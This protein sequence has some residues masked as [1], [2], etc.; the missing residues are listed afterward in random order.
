[1]TGASVVG[2]TGIVKDQHAGMANENTK[3]RENRG[4]THRRAKNVSRG[5]AAGFVCAVDRICGIRVGMDVVVLCSGGM[6]SVTAL[7]WAQARWRVAAALSFDYGAKHNAREIPFAAEHAA[8]LGIP[9]QTIALPF[10]NDLFASDLLMSGGEI[11]SGS[12]VAFTRNPSTGE[13]T[14]Y[15]EYLPNVQ[16]EDLVSGTRTPEALGIA[17]TRPGRES[18]T[19]ERTHPVT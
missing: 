19:L 8:G 9:H 17:T 11:T 1:M 4:P 2:A 5:R 7:H 14:L 12:I 18:Q 16:G 3:L 10:V 13:R 6:D 15:G